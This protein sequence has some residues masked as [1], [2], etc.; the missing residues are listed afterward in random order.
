MK[1]ISILIGLAHLLTKMLLKNFS[2]L[3]KLEM[4][5][6]AVMMLQ[7]LLIRPDNLA[8]LL[9]CVAVIKMAKGLRTSHNAP[10]VMLYMTTGKLVL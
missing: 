1:L 10:N 3:G 8:L 4:T 6:A 5:V 7:M 2:F 9:A